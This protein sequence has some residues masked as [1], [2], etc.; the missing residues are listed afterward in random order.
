MSCRQACS[1]QMVVVI[2]CDGRG[3]QRARGA[4]RAVGE[5]VVRG[6]LDTLDL[7]VFGDERMLENRS[8]RELAVI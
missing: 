2:G 6:R 5:V 8:V 1:W 3:V 7:S 4:G